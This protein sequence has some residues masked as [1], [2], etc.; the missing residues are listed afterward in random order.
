MRVESQIDTS[1]PKVPFFEGL[2]EFVPRSNSLLGSDYELNLL[3]GSRTFVFFYLNVHSVAFLEALAPFLPEVG[4]TEHPTEVPGWPPADWLLGKIHPCPQGG[5]PTHNL[6]QPGLPEV[7]VQLRCPG[8]A[9]GEQFKQILETV[10]MLF[11]KFITMF[12]A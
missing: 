10:F 6:P 4:E 8:P 12:C 2:E 3:Q 1:L 9:D 7:K 5:L 11:M